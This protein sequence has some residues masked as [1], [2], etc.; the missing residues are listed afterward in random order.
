VLSTLKPEQL[1]P[2]DF[3]D[4]SNKTMRTISFGGMSHVPA[5]EGGGVIAKTTQ[6]Y[7][8]PRGRKFPDHA[9]GFLY[10]HQDLN[11]PLKSSIRLRCTQ[12]T[13]PATFDQGKDLIR[14]AGQPWAVPMSTILHSRSAYIR[15]YLLHAGILTDQ[16]II[17]WKSSLKY[18][19]P[20]GP[21]R[22][23]PVLSTLKPDELLPSDF[24]D[25]SYKSSEMISFIGVPA[26]DKARLSYH[27]N[28]ARFPD[29]ARGFLYYHQPMN[30]PPI[31]AS[32]RL[33]CTPSNDPATF[34]QG[35]DLLNPIGLLPW[36]VKMP[37]ILS[38][39]SPQFRDY[40]LRARIVTEAQM[41]Q[42]KHM[43]MLNGKIN[44]PRH[45]IYRLDQPFLVKFHSYGMRLVTVVGDFI[46]HLRLER[47]FW[48]T[49]R[50]YKAPYRGL[51]SNM[52]LLLHQS[53]DVSFHRFGFLYNGIIL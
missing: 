7:F 14:R 33:R 39:R 3:L 37:A 53:H 41:I 52:C 13:D 24:V 12:S 49:R 47:T 19:T 8:G 45:A 4:M 38:I 31:A 36:E 26:P 50:Q 48:D 17:R 2:T 5:V 16:Q 34:N 35:N 20:K 21:P 6:L 23:C 1:L 30:M 15:N 28:N 44:C 29:H 22:Y 43:H 32:I 51:V 27:T 40:L 25:L 42:W 46:G 18:P 9:R 11:E 10:L